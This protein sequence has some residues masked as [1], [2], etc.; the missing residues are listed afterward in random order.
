MGWNSPRVATQDTNRYVEI[1]TSR[2]E[3]IYIEIYA[4][5]IEG[6]STIL[7]MTA[8]QARNLRDQINVAL[9]TV[10]ED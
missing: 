8:S 6:G 4:E 7:E 2:G 1:E 3:R 9:Y 10:G 5:H